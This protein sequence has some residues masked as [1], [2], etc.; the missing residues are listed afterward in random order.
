MPKWMLIL[1]NNKNHWFIYLQFSS[2]PC[3]FSSASSA[4]P[5]DLWCR[6]WRQSSHT[7]LDGRSS[8]SPT[9]P[10]QE[11]RP[12]VSAPWRCRTRRNNVREQVMGWRL[13]R[14]LRN[15]SLSGTIEKFPTGSQ[16]QCFTLCLFS[17]FYTWIILFSTNVLSVPQDMSHKGMGMVVCLPVC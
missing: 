8:R 14:V 5:S 16:R 11:C 15:Y 4:D 7:H 13:Q 2:P 17:V 12:A 9:R 1:I 6:T 3:G 10:P